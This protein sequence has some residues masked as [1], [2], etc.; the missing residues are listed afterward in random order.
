MAAE[1]DLLFVYGTLRP[2]LSSEG[3]RLVRDLESLGEATVRGVLY[4][5]GDYP[6]MVVG[7]GLVHGDVLRVKSME[8]LAALD[9]YEECDRPA[10]L[11]H[12]IVT[13]ARSRDGSECMAW[14]YVYAREVADATRIDH[15]D[16]AAWRS[17]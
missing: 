15:G 6:G 12:R 9:T 17:R 3:S 5:L 4:D 2:G 11:F 13:T 8:Q 10:P 1:P 16:Y 14:V 7:D